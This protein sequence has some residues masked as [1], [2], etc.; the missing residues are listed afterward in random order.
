MAVPTLNKSEFDELQSYIHSN[1]G[2][3]LPDG[4]MTMVEQRIRPLV[5]DAGLPTFSDFIRLKLKS[6]SATDLTEFVNRIT[7]NHTYFARESEHFDYLKKTVLPEL[8][9]I[10]KRETQEGS[11]HVF[12]M[13]C[14]AAS[15]GH[16]PYTLAM[17]QRQ[18]FGAEYPRWDAGLLATDISERSLKYAIRGYYPSDEVEAL[19]ADMRQKFFTK[20]GDEWEV[21]PE[22]RK[23]VL[24]R[25][26]NLNN[27][28]YRF[29]RPFD[30]VFCRNVLIYFNMPTKLEVVGKICDQLR[31]GGYLFLGLAESIG[32]GTA[33]LKY[34][35]P[36]VYKKSR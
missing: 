9:P 14:S 26:F 4:K 2:I 16:E 29:R 27:D 7:T 11:K 18:Y 22:L 30:V 32:R 13:W 1:F 5:V 12:R 24:F 8:T 28:R 10:I 35:Q 34:V 3:W 15:R 19:P 17:L 6:P 36:G 21:V 20:R 33:G 31:P 25:S 23:D